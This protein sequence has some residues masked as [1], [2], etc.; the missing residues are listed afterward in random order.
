MGFQLVIDRPECVS[1]VAPPTTT[2]AMIISATT[3]SQPRTSRRAGRRWRGTGATI[4]A[5]TVVSAVM[6]CVL[7]AAFDIAG[8]LP[9]QMR[10]LTRP[11]E[12]V[13]GAA[14]NRPKSHRDP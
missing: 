1:R 11:S 4:A 12:P 7:L 5:G 8:A 9:A 2:I 3:T 10:H 13:N 14:Q 6:A